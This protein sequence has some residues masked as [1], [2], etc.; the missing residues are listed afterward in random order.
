MTERRVWSIE[1]D[2]QPLA[3]GSSGD[4]HVQMAALHRALIRKYGSDR[5]K[6]REGEDEWPEVWIRFE[7]R[8]EAEEAKDDVDSILDAHAC[9]YCRIIGFYGELEG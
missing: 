4:I 7:S 2:E 1:N 5:A 9:G 3:G 6:R 8:P